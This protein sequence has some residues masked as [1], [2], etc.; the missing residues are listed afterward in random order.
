MAFCLNKGNMG[1]RFTKEYLDSF[2]GSKQGQIKVLSHLKKGKNNANYFRCQCDCGRISEI[3]TKHFFNDN[4][5]TCGRFHK[6]YENSEIGEKLYN[7]WNR[8]IHRCY[9]TKNHK[10]YSYGARGIKVCDEW[11]NDYDT[12]YKWAIQSGYQIGL[13]IE[14]IDNNGNYCPQNCKWATRTEQM[15]NTR[16]TKHIC[17]KGKIHS[18]AEWCEIL[19]LYYPTVNGRLFKGWSVER[20]FDTPTNKSYDGTH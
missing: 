8:M 15:R 4:Q 11:K 14:R 16:R 6:K 13:W 5:L 1:K 10:Y 2:I 7:T 20:A 12:F 17:Y 18:L 3:S 9:D 19:D